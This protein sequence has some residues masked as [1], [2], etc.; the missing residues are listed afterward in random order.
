[1][2]ST[3]PRVAR[4]AI[5][6]VVG[7]RTLALVGASRGKKHKFGNVALR[8]LRTRGYRVLP[9]HPEAETL[10]G[11]RCYRSLAELPEP[12]GAVV[13]VVPPVQSERVVRAAAEAKIRRVW[14]QQG[15][16]SDEAIRFCQAQGMTVVYKECIL[17]F[18]EPTGFPHSLHRFVLRLF[19][20]LPR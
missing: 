12:V 19:G 10:E 4:A 16:E 11:E 7:E 6:E 17:M 20:R 2:S 8:E 18:A 15:A 1:M 13:V 14:L 9:V 3:L 5:D